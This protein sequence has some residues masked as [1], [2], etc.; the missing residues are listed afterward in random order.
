[1]TNNISMLDFIFI[2][3]QNFDFHFLFI[4]TLLFFAFFLFFNFLINFKPISNFISEYQGIQ[5]VHEGEVQRIGGLIIFLIFSIFTL[6]SKSDSNIFNILVVFSPLFLITLIEDIIYPIHYKVRLFLMFLSSL[7]IIFFFI[8]KLPII[9]GIPLVSKLFEIDI[10]NKLFFVIALVTLMNGFN[11]IDGM[12]GLLGF[13]VIGSLL[14]I[15]SLYYVASY[16]IFL[17]EIFILIILLFLFILL[18]YPWGKIFMGDSGAYFFAFI[19]G[20]IVIDFFGSNVNISSWNACL[21]FFYPT[22]EVIYSFIRKIYNCKSPF[23]PDREHLH[24][25]IYDLIIKGT[26]KPRLSNNLTTIFLSLFL[27]IPPLMI[28]LFYD[29]QAV[30]IFSVLLLTVTYILINLYI[31]STYSKK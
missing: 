14:S 16:T 28:K 22:I 30:I 17:N 25:K 24:L 10:A 26:N 1:M 12:N 20:M 7:I 4:L 2:N 9:D 3:F 29:N 15:L 13:Y 23:S 19:L 5:R 18:N 27:S 8:T 31:P 21:I 6:F 11:F